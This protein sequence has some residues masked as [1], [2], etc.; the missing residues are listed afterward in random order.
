MQFYVELRKVQRRC[1]KGLAFCLEKIADLIEWFYEKTRD[2]QYNLEHK[3][4]TLD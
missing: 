4:R 1:I 2:T 3:S